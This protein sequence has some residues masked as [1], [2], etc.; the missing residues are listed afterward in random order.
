VDYGTSLFI[1]GLVYTQDGRS[2]V[3]TI[4]RRRFRVIE[5]GMRDGYN[6]ARV[7]LIRDDAIEQHEFDGLF[8]LSETPR[9]SFFNFILLDLFQLNR[10]T[11]TRVRQWFDNLDTYR[12][13]LMTQQLEEYPRCDD[14]TAGSSKSL[15][16]FIF[17]SSIMFYLFS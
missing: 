9:I 14:L 5:R 2:I 16:R 1:R 6:T 3:D 7:Q 15:K 11:Y 10:D 13:T 17:L 8:S 12:K 4:G